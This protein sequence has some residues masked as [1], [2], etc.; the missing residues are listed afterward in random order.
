LII[1]RKKKIRE[2][3]DKYGL[4]AKKQKARID[5]QLAGKCS[6]CQVLAGLIIRHSCSWAHPAEEILCNS[7]NIGD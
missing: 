4:S 3:A 6:P 7:C 2:Q 5:L 1:A